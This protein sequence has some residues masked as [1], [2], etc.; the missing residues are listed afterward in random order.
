[1]TM[2]QAEAIECLAGLA[3]SDMDWS[4]TAD[5]CT[6]WA[7]HVVELDPD[8]VA[9]VHR[10]LD[11]GTDQARQCVMD[12]LS[13][14]CMLNGNETSRT[15]SAYKYS[16]PPF[17]NN[18]V[19]GAWTT[20]NVRSE[21]PGLSAFVYGGMSATLAFL[22][23]NL[24]PEGDGA[25]HFGNPGYWRGLAVLTLSE[26]TP[27]TDTIEQQD[28][29]KRFA[30]LPGGHPDLQQTIDIINA[31]RSYDAG[32]VSGLLDAAAGI[33]RPMRSGVL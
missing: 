20:G 5:Q 33:T 2:H 25:E 30:A 19:M 8:F 4:L 31:H 6:K 21:L 10:L 3:N 23:E 15:N 13:T 26:V 24:H 27:K 9:L 12:R 18:M 32:L 1:M 14:A 17:L 28:E 29:V 11:S 16:C 7:A 22:H